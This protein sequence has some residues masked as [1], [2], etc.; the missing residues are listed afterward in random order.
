MH[1]TLHFYKFQ[2][3]LELNVNITEMAEQL[4]TMSRVKLGGFW[5]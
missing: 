5:S 1:Q 4:N 3:F 2:T